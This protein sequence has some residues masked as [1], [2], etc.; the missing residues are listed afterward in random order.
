MDWGNFWL[1]LWENHRGK[2]IGVLLGLVFGLMV[3]SFGF[4][5]ALF[6]TLCI[7]IGF[8]IGRR[9]DNKLGFKESISKIFEKNNQ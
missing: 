2:V 7:L 6:V 9:L 1:E 8:W 4:F 3:I 5:K